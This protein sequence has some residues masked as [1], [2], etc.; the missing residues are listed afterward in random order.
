MAERSDTSSWYLY[1][2]EDDRG[3]FYSGITTDV[4]RRFQE[5][6]DVYA[7]LPGAKGAKF[8][9]S[10]RPLRV[11]YQEACADR[12][13]ATRRERALKALPKSRKKALIAGVPVEDF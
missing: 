9:R 4:A 10:S 5:H 3:R 13:E 12:G 7:R 6:C 8:F 2:I 1:M 11:V